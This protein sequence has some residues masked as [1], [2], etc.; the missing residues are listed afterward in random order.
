MNGPG[1][2]AG[3]GRAP[4]WAR[5]LLPLALTALGA[6]AGYLYYWKV[7][8]AAGTCPIAASPWRSMLYCGA[9]G[10]LLSLAA[11]PA[12]RKEAGEGETQ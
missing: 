2:E 3:K 11:A 10:L 1:G 9:I 6:A 5:W 7:G 8:C 12:K 4:A